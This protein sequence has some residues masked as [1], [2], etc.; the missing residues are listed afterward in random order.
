M[1]QRWIA[2]AKR[3][4]GMAAAAAAA[5][6]VTS[7]GPVSPAAAWDPSSTHLGLAE[8]ALVEAPLHRRWMDGS[9]LRRGVFSALRID[10][11]RLSDTERRLITRAQRAAH[12]HVGAR[13]RGGPGACPGASAPPATRALC[14]EGDLWEATARGWVSLGII[15]EIVPRERLLHHFMDPA[16]PRAPTW[17]DDDVPAVVSRA[18]QRHAD[19]P[20]LAA[21]T[22]SAFD[23]GGTSA[24][25]WLT[26]TRDPW[27]PPAMAKHLQAAS[28]LRDRAARE[29][30]LALAMI[31]VGAL[32][33]VMQDAAVPAHAR[34]DLAA[35]FAPLS[36]TPGDRGLPLAEFVRLAHGRRGLPQAVS[37]RPRD[38]ADAV[39]ARPT[40]DSLEDEL[41]R[42]AEIAGRRFLSDGDVPRDVPVGLDATAQEAAQAV[43]VGLGLDP[44]E[45]EGAQ[46]AP[47]PAEA[48]YLLSSAGRPLAAFARDDIGRV[49]LRLD[50]RVYRDQAGQLLPLAIEASRAV[51]DFVVPAFPP[52]T[53]R[54]GGSVL[55][56][57]LREHP[58][59]DPTLVV[60]LEDP[61]GTRSVYRRVTVAAG[62][63]QRLVGAV[64]SAT[65]DQRIVLVLEVPRGGLP[66]VAEMELAAAPSDTSNPSGATP[67][68]TAPAGGAPPSPR[69]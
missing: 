20:G 45:T 48:G 63:R 2:R 40:I 1:T 16:D 64:P 24:A 57:D 5:C 38:S 3:R 17:R 22:G 32:L 26:D 55:E 25:A 31:G 34:G 8:R 44:I 53:H 39:P 69:R 18:L 21:L 51:L 12:A 29:H 61:D 60:M 10:P 14:V 66:R 49:T 36:D 7:L 47:W 15:A 42:V 41:V 43:V 37:L 33:H 65:A 28:L 46:M 13:S 6:L 58:G 67:L 11:A 9:G 68:T 27:A 56:L 23:G 4:I 35:A 59:D 62:T 30:H 19:G 52:V 54:P 50:R